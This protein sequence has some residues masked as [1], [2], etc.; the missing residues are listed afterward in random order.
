MPNLFAS[1]PYGMVFEHFQNYF[2]F[3]DFANGFLQLFQFCS[4]ITQGHISCQIAHILGVAYL[5]AI[6]KRLGGAHPI[7]VKE[8]LY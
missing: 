7:V 6:I 4:H 3:E 5:L 1:G 2:H 8:I